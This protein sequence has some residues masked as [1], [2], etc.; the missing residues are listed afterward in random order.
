[1]EI[2]IQYHMIIIMNRIQINKVLYKRHLIMHELSQLPIRVSNVLNQ[3]CMNSLAAKKSKTG[4][5]AIR[6][7]LISW[8]FQRILC[9]L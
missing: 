4:Q 1:M 3:P 2:L 8:N 6:K 9:S 5:S 7:D